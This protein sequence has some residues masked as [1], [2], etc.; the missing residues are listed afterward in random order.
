[1]SNL[2]VATLDDFKVKGK[3]VFVRSDINSPID[4]E[5][6]KIVDDTRIRR[7]LPTLVELTDREAKVVLLAHQGDPLDY[8]NFMSLEQHSSYLSE[9]LTPEVRYIQDTTGPAA[10]KSIRELTPGKILLLENVRIHTEE[11]II[12]EEQAKLTPQQQAKT[13]LV[14]KIAPLGQI[15]ICDAFAAVHRSEPTL[16]GFPEL[17]PSGA[18]RLFEEELTALTRVTSS[19]ESPSVFLLGGAKILDAFKMMQKVLD[20]GSADLILTYGLVGQVMLIADGVDLGEKSYNFLHD[21]ELLRY[22]SEAHALLESYRD[23]I[24]L[25]KDVAVEDNGTRREIQVTELPADSEIYDI[26]TDTVDWYTKQILS[27]KTLFLNGPAGVYE[28]PLFE[29]GTKSIFTA[30]SQS[31]GFSVIGGGDSIAASKRFNVLDDFSYVCTAGGGLIRFL[32]GEQLPVINALER[33][34]QKWTDPT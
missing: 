25:P 16:V 30:V 31:D 12:F 29:Y 32:S 34:K 33:A 3:T 4:Q 11:T 10:L 24:A 1:M 23:K 28:N 2:N 15:Y 20:D 26:G 5:S 18:G 27:A 9:Y 14:N 7:S 22:E 21:A 13:Y 6:R 17:M 19:P 8:Q